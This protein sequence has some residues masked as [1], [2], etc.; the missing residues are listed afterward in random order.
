MSLTIDEEGHQGL[1]AL[2]AVS[3]TADGAYDAGAVYEAAQG[4]RGRAASDSAHP[5]RPGAQPS[6]AGSQRR[7]GKL[8]SQGRSVRSF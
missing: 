2:L 8:V 7:S 5:A 6:S 3:V 1:T 4:K